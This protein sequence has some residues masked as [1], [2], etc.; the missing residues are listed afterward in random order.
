MGRNRNFDRNF[1]GISNLGWEGMYKVK[2]EGEGVYCHCN[3]CNINVS[4]KQAES[5]ASHAVQCEY[6][7]LLALVISDAL[8]KSREKSSEESVEVDIKSLTD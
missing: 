3:Y 4:A 2:K 5:L 6:T 7:S 1:S 8:N